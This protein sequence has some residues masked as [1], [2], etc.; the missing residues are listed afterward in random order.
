MNMCW[1]LS[2][3]VWAFKDRTV[4][5]RH[6]CHHS[7]CGGVCGMRVNDVEK[8]TCITYIRDVT[9]DGGTLKV[10]PLRNF[11]VVSDLVVDMGIAFLPAPR[12]RWAHDQFFQCPRQRS[13]IRF[14]LATDD[15]RVHP[16]CGLYRMRT[17]HQRLSSRGNFQ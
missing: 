17:L 15:E 10:E 14:P 4:C 9:R 16:P 13:R 3:R 6:A 12:N 8:L 2:I 7:T 1:M 5:F 11:P